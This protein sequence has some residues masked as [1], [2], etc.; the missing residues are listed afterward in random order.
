[1]SR[2]GRL[3]GQGPGQYRNSPLNGF[4]SPMI[5]VAN[6]LPSIPMGS[7]QMNPSKGG[8]RMSLADMQAPGGFGG[9]SPLAQE[10]FPQQNDYVVGRPNMDILTG[11]YATPNF[12]QGLQQPAMMQMQ[13]MP[14]SSYGSPGKGMRPRPYGGSFGGSFYQGYGV[15][16]GIGSLLSSYPSY[17]PFNPYMR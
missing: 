11:N 16:R 5:R 12:E 4:G 2:G 14:F 10:K 9:P 6:P 15:P 7:P 13:P 8:S 1:M 3:G 17:M